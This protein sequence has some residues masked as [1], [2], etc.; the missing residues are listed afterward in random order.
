MFATIDL[1]SLATVTGGA[2]TEL[3]YNGNQVDPSDPPEGWSINQSGGALNIDINLGGRSAGTAGT[4]GT[5]GAAGTAG[6]AGSSSRRRNKKV[7]SP[8]QSQSQ[9]PSASE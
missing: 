8:V 6:I 7:I 1:A 3:W 5:E 4:T 2:Q 9:A